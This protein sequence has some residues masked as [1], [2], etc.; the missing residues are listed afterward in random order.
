VTEAV[1]CCR[2]FG[3]AGRPP[4][5]RLAADVAAFLFER[6]DA[7]TRRAV[8]H[9]RAWRQLLEGLLFGGFLA[10]R[11]GGAPF[12]PCRLPERDMDDVDDRPRDD[13]LRPLLEAR[14]ID[15][16]R[17]DPHDAPGALTVRGLGNRKEVFAEV[18]RSEGVEVFEG[19]MALLRTLRAKGRGPVRRGR[20]WRCSALLPGSRPATGCGD[21]AR[22]GAPDAPDG[23][24]PYRPPLARALRLSVAKLAARGRAQASVSRS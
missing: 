18:M 13:G 14:R 11:A 8:V 3:G 2:T 19:S 9:A 4:S 17:G 6:D 23:R 1:T 16:P 15:L 21:R 12:R 7:L 5:D 24:G 10:A 20:R 22:I